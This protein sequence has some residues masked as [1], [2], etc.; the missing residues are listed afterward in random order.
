MA[1]SGAMPDRAPSTMRRVLAGTGWLLLALLVVA[2]SWMAAALA[3]GFSRTPAVAAEARPAPEDIER[4]LALLKRHDPRWQRPG[5]V[6]AAAAD[7]RDVNLLATQAAARVPGLRASVRL[8]RKRADVALSVDAARLMG[9]APGFAGRG[10]GWWFN[11]HAELVS[12]GGSVPALDSLRLGP[13]PVP[14]LLGEALVSLALSR[15]GSGLDFQL[16]R[17]VIRRV[18]LHEKRLIAFYVWQDDTSARLLQALTPQVEQQRLRAY[19]DVLV[20]WSRAQAPGATVTLASLLR[21]MFDTAKRRSAAGGDAVAENRAA[22]LTATLYANRRGIS[23][24]VP[25]ARDWP[26]PR[27]MAV[28]LA[29]RLDTPLHYL[30]SAAL[31]AESGSP[32]ADAVGLYKEL[33]DSRGGSGFSFNDLAADRAGTRVGEK[34]RRD[35]L[36][37]QAQLGPALDEAALLPDISDLPEHLSQEQFEQ[38]YGGVGAPAYA[39]MVAEIDARLDRL[40]LLR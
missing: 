19:A 6:R 33:A 36:R 23:A 39:R 17:D 5:I 26:R 37:L 7:E 10:S 13:V 11:V 16:L 31:A 18:D 2:A 15:Y 20:Q 1:D 27:W 25:A 30:I 22:L 3:L 4:A 9:A 32:L 21:A 12:N 8:Q 38:R 34:A 28:T 29:G 14:A 40:P 35:P 24:V